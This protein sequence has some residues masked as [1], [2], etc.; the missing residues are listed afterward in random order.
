MVFLLSANA[1][2]S[3]TQVLG[4][5]VHLASLGSED[6]PSVRSAVSAHIFFEVCPLLSMPVSGLSPNLVVTPEHPCSRTIK[7]II[8]LVGAMHHR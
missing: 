7:N 2:Q 8:Y 4:S 6:S 1:S 5:G 3:G